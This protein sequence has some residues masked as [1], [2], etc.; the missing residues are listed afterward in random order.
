MI[1]L[2]TCHTWAFLKYS[3]IPYLAQCLAHSIAPWIVI[4]QLSTHV[5]KL[6]VL[7]PYS[8]GMSG[9]LC[10]VKWT[11]QGESSC[12]AETSDAVATD[13][14]INLRGAF[15]PDANPPLLIFLFPLP[16]RESKSNLFLQGLMCLGGHY[17][18]SSSRCSEALEP[19][20]SPAGF[21]LSCTIYTK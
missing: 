2:A 12:L 7:L 10:Q 8:P 11:L 19:G 9:A 5:V 17:H 18:V 20:T 3:F 6:A 16:I 1:Y 21:T 14:H 13:P 4:E 15:P